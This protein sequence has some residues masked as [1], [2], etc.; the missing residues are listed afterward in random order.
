MESDD[1]REEDLV[2]GEALWREPDIKAKRGQD[3]QRYCVLRMEMR[4]VL[5]EGA[6]RKE[7]TKNEES[8]VDVEQRSRLLNK[9]ELVSLA[10]VK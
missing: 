5:N 1:G 8:G 9:T 10:Q 4:K 6:V 2:E 3:N 7:I